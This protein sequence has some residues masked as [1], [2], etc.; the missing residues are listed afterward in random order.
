MAHIAA[1]GHGTRTELTPDEANEIAR[2]SEPKQIDCEATSDLAIGTEVTVVTEGYGLDGVQ[3]TVIRTT[4][5]EIS[6]KRSDPLV[7][8][9]HVHFPHLGSEVNIV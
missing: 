5:Q 9:V 4:P 3:G 6:I 8:T 2:N 1:L 7:G